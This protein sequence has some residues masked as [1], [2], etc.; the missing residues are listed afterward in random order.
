[1]IDEMNRTIEA[2]FERRRC[3]QLNCIR[4]GFI[5]AGRVGVSLGK[6]LKEK[7][8]NISGY[9]S[10]SPESAEYAAE[11]T[12][13]TCF[14]S[15]NEVIA[16]SD[17]LFFTVPDNS[18]GK[19]WEEAKLY[20]SNKIICHCSGLHSSKIFSDSGIKNNCA[21]SIHPLFAVS[22]KENSWKE[23]PDILFTLEGDEKYLNQIEEMFNDM[24]NRTRIISDNN[25][26]KY[27][28]A[29]ALSSNYMTALFFMAEKLFLECGFD[30]KEATEELYALAKGN[31]ENI[32][33]MG[34]V[35][36]LTGPLERNDIETVRKHINSLDPEMRKVY[37]ANAEYLIKVA[38]KRH[39][40]RDYTSM[41][42]ICENHM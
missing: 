5:G 18:I 20:V 10:Q 36:A 24:G 12:N 4:I 35:N 26:I 42:E 30:E 11:F 32:L 9:Y 6:Y 29:A 13:S 40:D 7:G 22:S 28:A 41:R 2:A 19:V 27:H 37:Q 23:F 21:Y 17:M 8:M 39:P 34:C 15:L 31:L 16:S 25:K 33:N 3:I 38:A 14:K 1:M